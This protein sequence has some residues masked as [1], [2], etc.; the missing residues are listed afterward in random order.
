MAAFYA[1]PIR[2]SEAENRRA[3]DTIAVLSRTVRRYRNENR[4]D[5]FE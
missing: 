2:L 3:E 5:R 4:Y 1:K